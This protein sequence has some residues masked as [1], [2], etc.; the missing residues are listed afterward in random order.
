MYVPSASSSFAVVL[1]LKWA[2]S[3]LI[4]LILLSYLPMLSRLIAFYIHLTEVNL[5]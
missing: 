2:S 5:G 1:A 3:C 4:L